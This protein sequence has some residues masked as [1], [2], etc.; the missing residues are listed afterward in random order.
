MALILS[1]KGRFIRTTTALPNPHKWHQ[2]TLHVK[3]LFHKS[4]LRGDKFNLSNSLRGEFQ[5]RITQVEFWFAACMQYQIVNT[6]QGTR[7]AS[8]P[9]TDTCPEHDRTST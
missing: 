5:N 4:S 9:H 1:H 7:A 6:E 2:A 3:S 8:T